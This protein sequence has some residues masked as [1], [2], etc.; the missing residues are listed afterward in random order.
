MIFLCIK[1]NSFPTKR[2]IQRSCVISDLEVV[3][4]LT[5]TLIV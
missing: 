4:D 2:V 1:V 3:A 5:E